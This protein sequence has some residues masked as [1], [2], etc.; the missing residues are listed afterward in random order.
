MH[1]LCINNLS[2]ILFVLT[3]LHVTRLH[4]HSVAASLIFSF[5]SNMWFSISGKAFSFTS[6]ILQENQV[7]T[8]KQSSWG[9]LGKW[10]SFTFFCS[11][12]AASQDIKNATLVFHWNQPCWWVLGEPRSSLLPLCLCAAGWLE[13]VSLHISIKKKSPRRTEVLTAE[14]CFYC[15]GET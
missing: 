2:V 3:S 6:F 13:V 12:T 8:F 4:M 11:A 9:L 1:Y 15:A 14:N 10:F 5:S 7:E